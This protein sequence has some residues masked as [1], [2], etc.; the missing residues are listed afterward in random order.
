MQ[1]FYS[2]FVW[3]RPVRHV[4]DGE[5]PMSQYKDSTVISGLLTDDLCLSLRGLL[6]PLHRYYGTTLTAVS[7]VIRIVRFPAAVSQGSS[8]PRRQLSTFQSSYLFISAF[9]CSLWACPQYAA[10]NGIG[11]FAT[12]NSTKPLRT[13]VSALWLFSHFTGIDPYI[14]KFVITCLHIQILTMSSL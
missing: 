9:R 6:S 2:I 1:F 5:R 4:S 12:G 13:C 10:C 11:F 8:P 3:Y 7:A 14:R